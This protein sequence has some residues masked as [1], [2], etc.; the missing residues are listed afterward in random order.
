MTVHIA[1][2]RGINVGGNNKVKMAELK[3]ACEQLGLE[4]VRTYIQS[5]NIVFRSDRSVKALREMLE[6]LLRENFG[7]KK[8]T[9][10][11]LTNAE[12]Q[13]LLRECPFSQA[14]I[15]AASQLY[16]N[17]LDMPP[18]AEQAARIGD[19]SADGEQCVIADRII[20]LLL[21]PSI[22]DSAFAILFQ[23]MKLTLTA[24]NWNTMNKLGELAAQTEQ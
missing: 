5:G 14:Q 13:R 4:G 15:A 12:L 23:K 21:T 7:V 6:T 24:R 3:S 9:V 17:L 8:A 10:L 2:L 20:Y 1:L 16:V 18:D 19:L 11:L 22:L